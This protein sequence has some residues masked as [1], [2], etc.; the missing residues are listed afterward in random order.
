MPRIPITVAYI[1][2]SKN[3]QVQRYSAEY[4][5]AA[6]R[7]LYEK[8]QD[9]I[10]EWVGH[11][12]DIEQ[13]ARKVC[14]SDRP[15]AKRLLNDLT[16][17]DHIIVHHF[18]RLERNGF[19]LVESLQHLKRRGITV[20]VVDFMGNELDMES[21]VGQF[22]IM[23]F[24]FAAQMEW[25]RISERTRESKKFLKSLG[26]PTNQH[27]GYGNKIVGNG[28]NKR[29]VPNHVEQQ[30]ID[31]AYEMHQKGYSIADIHR[32]FKRRDYKTPTGELWNYSRL[33]RAIIS[34]GAKRKQMQERQQ[35]EKQQPLATTT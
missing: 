23:A 29:I 12:A 1:R 35:A 27:A 11:Y 26:L 19:A 14:F 5:L 24:G 17:G 30:Q 10:P 25:E 21:A 8:K 31:T 20:H 2:Q 16:K 18:D 3:A 6:C 13:S 15:E 4:Q 33:R 7:Q 32:E 9:A 34:E 22:L 28:H